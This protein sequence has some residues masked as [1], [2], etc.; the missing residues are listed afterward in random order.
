MHNATRPMTPLAAVAA[1]L[2]AGAVGTI[3]LDAVHYSKYRRAGGAQGPLA[4]EF[5]PVKAWNDAPAPGQ[6][7]RR[8]IEG[9]TQRDLPD[10]WAW[11]GST[12]AH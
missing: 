8:V 10:R 2:L 1:S 3:G 4:R 5:A 7:A 12:A 11:A 9:F 6:V